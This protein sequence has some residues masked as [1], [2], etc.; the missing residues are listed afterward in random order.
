MKAFCFGSK[1]FV[2]SYLYNHLLESGWEVDEFN[3]RNG[4][5]IRNYE[6]VRNALDISR[7]NV[8]YVLAA[9]AAPAESFHN[10]QRA[11]EVNTI[12]STNILEAVRQLGLKATVVLCST[13]E[14]YGPEEPIEDG[15]NEPR[16]P[17]AI[18]K[19]A[20]EQMGQLYTRAYGMHIIITRAF[21][22]TG[23]GRGEQY[24]ESS[25]AKQVAEIEIGKRQIIEHGNLSSVRNFS[26]VRDIVRAYEMC[27]KLPS[28]VYNICSDTNV[29]IR[30]ILDYLDS[31]SASTIPTKTNESLI[32]PAD[33]NFQEPSSE[34]FRNLTGWK[35]EY[36]LEETL[37]NLLDY[38]RERV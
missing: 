28:G 27:S 22:H 38:W 17:Y 36:A 4:Q 19:L 18:S 29:P 32:R 33:F 14:V 35:P 10:P 12:G 8:I 13:S 7:P 3:L 11:F 30:Y 37:D 2:S 34:K 31:Q 25:F 5:D 6:T 21:N 9:M 16:S 23:P 24:A 1:G 15:K 20:M 26:D